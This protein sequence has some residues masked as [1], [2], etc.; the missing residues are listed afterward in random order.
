MVI[1][2]YTIIRELGAGG[3]ATVYLARQERLEREVAL[4]VLKPGQEDTL[5]FTARFIKESRIV[6]RLHH[7]H[8]V[9]IYDFDSAGP[10]HYFSMELLPGG[11]LAERIRAGLALEPGLEVM[12]GIASALAYAHGRGIVHRDIKP[13]NI[14][15]RQDGTPV[16]TDFGIARVNVADPA[17]TQLTQAGLM[18]GSP[19]YMS[20][21][22]VLGQPV[23]ARCDLY[24]LG[25]VFYEILTGRAPFTG[26]DPMT[27]A[28]KQC[29]EPVPPLP[30]EL[31]PFQPILD[32]LV[33]KQPAQRY[34]DAGQL[35]AA[36]TGLGAPTIAL[37]RANESGA[38]TRVIAPSS[39]GARIPSAP[40]VDAG[41]VTRPGGP[42][43]TAAAM[44]AVPRRQR[45]WPVVLMA[46]LTIGAALGWAWWQWLEPPAA[47]VDIAAGLPQAPE[48]RPGTAAYYERLAIEHFAAG[49]TARSGELI[50]LGLQVSPGDARLAALGERVAGWQA[51]DALVPEIEARAADDDLDG[52]LALL[53]EGLD[54]AARHPGLLALRGELRERA[55]AAAAHSEAEG[56]L[57]RA[58]AL[59]D[60]GDLDAAGERLEAG[61][62]LVPGHPGLLALQGRLAAAR[63][64][65]AAIDDTLARAQGLREQGRLDNGLVLLERERERLGADADLEA[66]RG[67]LAAELVEQRRARAEAAFEAARDLLAGDALDAGLGQIERG[68][69][70]VPEHR[71]LL[72]LKALVRARIQARRRAAELLAEARARLAAGNLVEAAALVEQGLGQVADAPDLLA[73]RDEIAQRR[74]QQARL[75]ELL[76]AVDEQR[77]T[78]DLAAAAEL[79]QH[80]LAMAPERIDL[81][82]LARGLHQAQAITAALARCDAALTFALVADADLARAAICYQALLPLAPADDGLA[83]VPETGPGVAREALDVLALALANQA[84]AGTADGDWPR[85]RR[86]E[87]MLHD[88]LPDHPESRRLADALAA[89][90]QRVAALPDLVEIQAGCFEIGSPLDETGRDDDE[91]P[92]TVCVEAFEIGRREVT[93]GEFRRFVEASGYLTDAERNSAAGCWSLDGDDA[94]WG[95]QPWASWRQPLRQQAPADAQPVVCLSWHDALTYSDWLSA[96]TGARLR[97]PTEA[98]WEFAARAGTPAARFWEP[99]DAAAACQYANV[100]DEGNSWHGGFPCDDGHTWLAPVGSYRANPWG[101]EDMLGNAAEW[102]CSA[103]ASRYEGAEADCSGRE[104][105]APRVVRGGSWF[106]GP[107][108]L[109]AAYRDRAFPESRYSF[110]GLRLVREPDTTPAAVE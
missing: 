35:I 44:A 66:L 16:L 64:R 83:Q 84:R 46:A 18:M 59:L 86:R 42:P 32:R 34:A 47:P 2:G 49:E 1:P 26:G 19:M 41:A 58:S 12:R 89:A 22:Q 101:L 92:H 53:D 29:N 40:R 13:H 91:G 99:A 105:S 76:T 106:S 69:M 4:K 71:G 74:E 15:F 78:G 82:R 43:P 27:L 56:L 108:T 6:A 81:Q 61:L 8:I 36:L 25:I 110:I 85:A 63:E 9:T 107:D 62:L 52:A 94:G 95:D 67:E 90:S 45:R 31:A 20:P 65:R 70:E 51:A 73:L 14:L 93:Q 98:E 109:R 28:V 50:E 54:Q 7:R 17:A 11:T 97:L 77:T 3:M 100:A 30:P 39:R 102:T 72:D 88:L 60:A 10:Y 38:A 33:A 75:D 55:R 48:G 79:A 57:A 68:L 23:D 80:A 37:A 103:Y 104:S 87:A 24:S 5:D 21:E 96:V